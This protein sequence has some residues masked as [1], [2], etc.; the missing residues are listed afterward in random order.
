M[1]LAI[2]LVDPRVVRFQGR[3]KMCFKRSASPR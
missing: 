1:R 3:Y 2:L